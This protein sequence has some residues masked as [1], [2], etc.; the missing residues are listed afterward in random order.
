MSLINPGKYTATCQTFLRKEPNSRDKN[1]VTRKNSSVRVW[2]G[3]MKI[4]R[5]LSSS[6]QLYYFVS[7]LSMVCRHC[8]SLEH[9][10]KI[11]LQTGI[12]QDLVVCEPAE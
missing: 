8:D 10:Q 1:P 12:A 5:F 3:T 9:A 4:A 6:K 11:V 7:S 2:S